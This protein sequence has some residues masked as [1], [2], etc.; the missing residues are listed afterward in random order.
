MGLLSHIRQTRE[1]A[2]FIPSQ[3]VVTGD[4][5]PLGAPPA[6]GAGDV[7]GG[8]VWRGGG[9]YLRGRGVTP[10]VDAPDVSARVVVPHHRPPAQILPDVKEGQFTPDLAMGLWF[11]DPQPPIVHFVGRHTRVATDSY[12]SY[13][14]WG[15]SDV[16]SGLEGTLVLFPPRFPRASATRRSVAGSKA[17]NQLLN[18][19]NDNAQTIDVPIVRT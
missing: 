10:S 7:H 18:M 14:A 2:R 8:N 9:G 19:P 13:R 4:G 5:N 16:A 12:A 17:G 3:N 1:R 15:S 6:V 11:D